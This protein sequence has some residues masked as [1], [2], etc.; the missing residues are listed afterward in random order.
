MAG[1]SAG[2]SRKTGEGLVT[3][4]ASVFRAQRCTIE[5][6][7]GTDC[8]NPTSVGINDTATYRDTSR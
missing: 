4:I 8:A 3:V 7:F 2:H 6:D 1:R 5:L